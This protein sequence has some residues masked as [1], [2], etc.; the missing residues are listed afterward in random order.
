MSNEF[1]WSIIVG[2]AIG[3]VVSI[4]ANVTTP[5]VASY[6]QKSKL[7]WIERNKRK[8]LRN[9]EELLKFRDGREDKYFYFAAQWGTILVYQNFGIAFGLLAVLIKWHGGPDI[10]YL[11]IASLVASIFFVMGGMRIIQKLTVWYWRM[12]NF[13]EYKASLQRSGI[14]I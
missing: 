10:Q 9:F 4:I 3:F 1:W 12:N 5:L 7:G 6:F 13:E 8:A 11:G 2:A 14:A